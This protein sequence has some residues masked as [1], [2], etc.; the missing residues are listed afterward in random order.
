MAFAFLLAVLVQQIAGQ[1]PPPILVNHRGSITYVSTLWGSIVTDAELHA[2]PNTPLDYLGPK[3]LAL[4]E[5]PSS[6][7]IHVHGFQNT[8]QSAQNNLNALHAS[9]S[10]SGYTGQVVGFAWNWDPGLSH[11]DAAEA[12]ADLMGDELAIFISHLWLRWPDMPIY[13]T[14]HSLGARVVLGAIQ[15]LYDLG[16]PPSWPALQCIKGAAVIAAAVDNEVLEP[17]EDFGPVGGGTPPAGGGGSTPPQLRCHPFMFGMI[18][19]INT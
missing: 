3:L 13:L 15:S 17:G 5:C 11:F 6:I 10:D 8:L 1:A 18:C 9:A 2:P 14:S 16:N 4:P 12:A 19:L 7:L